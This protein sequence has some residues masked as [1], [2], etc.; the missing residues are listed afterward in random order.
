MEMYYAGLDVLRTSLLFVGSVV[1]FIGVVW[2]VLGALRTGFGPHVPRRIVGHMALGLGFYRGQS[3]EPDT[4]PD[5]DGDTGRGPDH[6]SAQARNDLLRPPRAGERRRVMIPGKDAPVSGGAVRRASGSWLF[7]LLLFA[8]GF[9]GLFWGAF[10]VLLADLS[11]A[12]DLSP[13]P[14]GFALFVGAAASILAM[15][16]SVGR[17]PVGTAT[18]PGS[19][20]ERVRGWHRRA[21]AYQELRDLLVAL[22]T[23]Y[24][25]SGLTT[26]G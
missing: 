26:W 5:L 23:L 11:G 25:A 16:L 22:V 7:V 3:L 21:G 18:V 1:I 20:G 2:A 4:R 15:A 10:A 9:F 19:V 6:H 8:F 12:L 17:R 13:G 24:A 14:L